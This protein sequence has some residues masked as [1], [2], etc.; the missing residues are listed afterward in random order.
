[1]TAFRATAV[2]VLLSSV[3]ANLYDVVQKHLLPPP[4]GCKNWNDAGVV[5]KYGANWVSGP[6]GP[7]GVGSACVQQGKGNT[8]ASWDADMGSGAQ[9]H[10]IASYCVSKTTNKVELCSSGMGVPEQVNVQIASGDT[11]VVGFVTYEDAAPAGPPTVEVNGTLVHG[12]TH[13]HDPCT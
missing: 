3:Q 6:A 1:M 4:G 5:E 13:T 11:V 10:V 2:A 12:V 9:G 7:E 8:D